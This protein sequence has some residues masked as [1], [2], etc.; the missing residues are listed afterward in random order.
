MAI[1]NHKGSL[2]EARVTHKRGNS[3][4]DAEWSVIKKKFKDGEIFFDISGESGIWTGVQDLMS[5]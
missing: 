4:T 2:P 1:C 5:G 3:G